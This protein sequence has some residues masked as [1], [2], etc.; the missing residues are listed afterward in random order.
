MYG[1][2]QR[3]SWGIEYSCEDYGKN[4]EDSVE[5]TDREVECKVVAAIGKGYSKR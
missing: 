4:M 1:K 2:G 3:D 5:S